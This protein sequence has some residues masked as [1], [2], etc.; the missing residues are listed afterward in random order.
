MRVSHET[1]YDPCRDRGELR[2][3]L[4]KLALHTAGPNGSAGPARPTTLTC[5]CIPRPTLIQ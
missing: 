5:P 4:K 1:M 2:T 3:D